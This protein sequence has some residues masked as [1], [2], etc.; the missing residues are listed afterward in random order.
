MIPWADVVKAAPGVI[1]RARNMMERDRAAAPVDVHSE[2]ITENTPVDEAL[3]LL[4]DDVTRLGE[5][6]AGLQEENLQRARLINTLAEQN[7]RLTETVIVLRRRVTVALLMGVIA[8]A[9]SAAAIFIVL[10]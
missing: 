1:T 9:A 3:T 4:R 8:I 7:G 5:M 10:R 2:S 6:V